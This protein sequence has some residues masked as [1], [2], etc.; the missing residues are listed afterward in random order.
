MTILTDEQGRPFERPQRD[1]F[2]SGV[3]YVRA[4]HEFNTR[5]AQCANKS[6]DKGFQD[7]LKGVLK[8]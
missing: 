3:D 6:F 7:L 2:I 1:R 8:A 4:V 5:V